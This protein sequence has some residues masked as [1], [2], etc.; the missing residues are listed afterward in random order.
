MEVNKTGIKFALLAFTFE[1]NAYRQKHEN[2][3]YNFLNSQVSIDISSPK[4][5]FSIVSIVLFALHD[6]ETGVHEIQ[7]RRVVLSFLQYIHASSELVYLSCCQISRRPNCRMRHV[8]VVSTNASIT[9]APIA[10]ATRIFLSHVKVSPP[11][12]LME[13]RLIL[14]V[15]LHLV[16][17][18]LGYY[19]PTGPAF[20][21]VC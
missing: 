11:L 16:R 4:T 19:R 15:R 20:F 12:S 6:V 21:N 2:F 8:H 14:L 18:V 7:N 3:H 17:F 13:I 10:F 1:L 5:S 9:V